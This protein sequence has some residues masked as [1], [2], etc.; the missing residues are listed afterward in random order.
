MPEWSVKVLKICYIGNYEIIQFRNYGQ[1]FFINY[2]ELDQADVFDTLRQYDLLLLEVSENCIDKIIRWI[3]NLHCKMN[4]PILAILD[5]CNKRD[6]L[7]LD[8]IGVRDYI[9]IDFEID[10]IESKIENMIRLISWQKK[11]K[12]V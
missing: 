1:V 8:K 9:D 4:I 12:M 11:N 6:K 10:K 5:N 3:F 7:K 2:S